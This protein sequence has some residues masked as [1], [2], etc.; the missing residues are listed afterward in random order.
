[1]PWRAEDLLNAVLAGEDSG[2][3]S[4]ASSNDPIAQRV[5]RYL[6]RA[7]GGL[8]TVRLSDADRTYT[9]PTIGQPTGP[10]A[11]PDTPP[12]EV[13]NHELLVC[14]GTGG[15][16]Q[17]WLARSRV[18]E[19]F[20]ACKLIPA[21][22]AIELGGLKWLKQRV[23]SHPN[24]FP[25]E[26]VGLAGDWIY[27]LMP[28][29]EGMGERRDNGAI[30]A[31]EP[32]TL[33]RMLDK[34]KRL[35]GDVAVDVGRAIALGLACLHP[36][37]LT[38]GDIKPSNVMRIDGRWAVSDYG[39][40]RESGDDASGGYTPGYVAPEGPGTQPSDVYALGVVLMLMI[41]GGV[42]GDLSAFLA[43]GS[44][45]LRREGVDPEWRRV[46]A[47]LTAADPEARPTATGV[48]R[49][50]DRL[51]P[52]GRKAR[53][54]RRVV[55]TAAG[56]A[57]AIGGMG[58]GG[59]AVN[60]WY[61][62]VISDRGMTKMRAAVFGGDHVPV[63]IS[64]L[65]FG[66]PGVVVDPKVS[67]AAGYGLAITEDGRVVV[68]GTK[69]WGVHNVPKEIVDPVLVRASVGRAMALQA[70]GTIVVWGEPEPINEINHSL[71]PDLPP[72]VD[73]RPTIFANTFVAFAD[74]TVR[75]WGENFKCSP[76]EPGT[77]DIPDGVDDIV[78]VH[79][80]NVH[81]VA[82]SADGT[83]YRIGCN[84]NRQ[85][86][87]PVEGREI[88]KVEPA[89]SWTLVLYGDGTIL[90]C[91]LGEQDVLKAPGGIG[92]IDI[93]A[94]AYTGLAL[95]EQGWVRWWGSIGTD[96]PVPRETLKNVVGVVS[97]DYIGG[98]VHDDGRL[99]I[100]G[101]NDDGECDPPAGLRVRLADP[102]E[103]GNG[104][105]DWK[106]RLR[107]AAGRGTP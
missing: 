78:S 60:A 57:L 48:A 21:D 77:L 39:L 75:G 64:P 71:P 102:D 67:L 7:D 28:L 27:C 4:Q 62:R 92:Y 36:R 37:G 106:D 104:I 101:A 55:L 51:S 83:V 11:W 44:R 59:L 24:L 52:V 65:A 99:T 3:G 5:H 33:R 18:T 80:L 74:G 94:G 8:L 12:V 47:M 89:E 17:V 87:F 49:L 53:R 105:A 43:Q 14:I 93:A 42:P 50:L 81:W 26:D 91:G 90:S 69:K 6:D 61:K 19:H 2:A 103:D 29:A 10:A 73:V 16:G 40:M 58:G 15:F 68:W 34:H 107:A 32:L 79:G 54:R 45:S 84:R 96:R 38:H 22:R 63:T 70:D 85:L 76:T 9:F 97:G 13:P 88:R 31:Y 25:I 82:V 86:A 46:V 1:M 20:R 56:L 72:A 41:R 95:S 66:K 30:D 23:A 98:V 100:W 35:S